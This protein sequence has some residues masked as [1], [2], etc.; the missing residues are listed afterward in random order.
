MKN[1]KKI[2]LILFVL[3]I[4]N[5]KA[6]NDLEY[7]TSHFYEYGWYYIS[8]VN[9]KNITILCYAN[10]NEYHKSG[11]PIYILQGTIEKP[12]KRNL[13]LGDGDPNAGLVQFK[14]LYSDP[15]KKNFILYP[16]SIWYKSNTGSKDQLELEA[17]E[18]TLDIYLAK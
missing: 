5:V 7:K 11:K 15:L 1:S 13:D 9:K 8:I 2:F 18:A 10:K 17:G 3:L 4:Q 16:G 6:Q 14:I 12:D